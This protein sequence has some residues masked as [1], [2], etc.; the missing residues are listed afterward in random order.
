[1]KVLVI[2]GNPKKSGA[3][4]T[5]TEEA[6]RGAGEDGA[7]VEWIRLREKDIGFCRFCL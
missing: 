2:T 5:L 3:L 7:E 4:A 6:A 1:M